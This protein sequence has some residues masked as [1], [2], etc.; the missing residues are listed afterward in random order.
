MD[1]IVEGSG[2]G[3]LGK[4]GFCWLE[5]VLRLLI[6]LYLRFRLGL[7]RSEYRVGSKIGRCVYS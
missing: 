4:Y 2:V 1:G 3:R 6:F 7:E 5:S